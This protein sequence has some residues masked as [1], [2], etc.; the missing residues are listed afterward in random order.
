MT[1]VKKLFSACLSAL[2]RCSVFLGLLVTKLIPS[3]GIRWN[4]LCVK[5]VDSKKTTITH[6]LKGEPVSFSFY[7]PNTLNLYRAKTFSTKEPETLEWIDQY[8]KE[9]D[10]F[11]DIG[12][13]IGL[14]SIYYAKSKKGIT[15]S[16]E[17]SVFNVKLLVKNINL[18]NCTERIR[19][20]TNPLTSE[21]SF[22]D[23]NLQST[24]EGGALSSFGV[25]YGHDGKKLNTQ[26]SYKTLGFSL[27][28]LVEQKMIPE[29]P[30]IIK[31]DVDGIEHLILRGARKVLAHPDCRSVLIEV[32]DSFVELA[33]EVEKVL[34]TTGFVLLEKRSVDADIE[35]VSNFTYN[36]IWIK[37]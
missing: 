8:A 35:S 37:K 5:Y 36:Q 13:N 20:I 3:I 34:L 1:F 16:F 6:L 31:I 10:T 2:H 26:V 9:G 4:E 32:N 27:D 12:A 17:P 28:Y 7:T 15:Y 30:A 22:A 33:A 25:D 21:N 14:Y 19:I 23:F 11:F 24:D 29:I 18:N